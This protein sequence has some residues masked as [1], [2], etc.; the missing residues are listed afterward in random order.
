MYHPIFLPAPNVSLS[1]TPRMFQKSA[2]HG[3]FPKS[4][5]RHA[6]SR[7]APVLMFGRICN[8]P[9]E[10]IGICNPGTVIAPRYCTTVSIRPTVELHYINMYSPS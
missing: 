1:F 9:A 10:S 8:Q 7:I 3:I 2:P 5:P 6:S 4:A